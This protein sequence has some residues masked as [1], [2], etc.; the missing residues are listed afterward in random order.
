[1]GGGFPADYLIKSN[2]L[3]IYAEE[4]NSYLKT[5]FGETPPAIYLEPGRGLRCV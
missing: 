5:Y 3:A 1:M 4:I 2:P